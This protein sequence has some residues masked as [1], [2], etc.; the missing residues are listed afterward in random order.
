MNEP[1]KKTS[2]GGGSKLPGSGWSWLVK[3]YAVLGVSALVTFLAAGVFGW[4]WG[5]EDRDALP[6]S[7]RQAPG[8]YR[9]YHLWH[10]GYQGG[11]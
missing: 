5:I 6:A 4:S 2:G 3:G 8:G 10:S 9:S 7:V 11:K 1:T